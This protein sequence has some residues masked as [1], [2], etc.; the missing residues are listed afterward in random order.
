VYR[1]AATEAGRVL[2]SN[3]IVQSILVRRSV[4]AGEVDFGRS[5]IDLTIVLK[6]PSETAEEAEKLLAL[7]R[8]YRRLRWCVPALG[9][10][11]VLTPEEVL[12]SYGADPYRASLE[13]RCGLV[14]QGPEVDIPE[15]PI[16]QSGVAY[17]TIDWFRGY[18]PIAVKTGNR[19][20]L[21]KFAI[22]IWNA[23]ATA[24]GLIEQPYITRGEAERAWQR[25]EPGLN[26]ARMSR[27]ELFRQC[28]RL[29]AR[30]HA[31]FRPPLPVLDRPLRLR[32][33]PT[34]YIVIPSPEYPLA[35]DELGWDAMVATP[36][37]LD[38]YL[39]HVSALGY[40]RLG[41]EI[42]DLGIRPPVYEEYVDAL[43]RALDPFRL[44]TIGFLD[45]PALVKGAARALKRSELVLRYLERGESPPIEEIRAIPKSS[46]PL[47]MPSDSEYYREWYPSLHRD[48]RALW[49]RL[50]ALPR[51]A[52]P[53]ADGQ[54]ASPS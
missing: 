11:F 24:T 15:L 12:R 20:N 27:S 23:Y 53:A 50:D 52:T 49:E 47:R 8:C 30:V 34:R 51:A 48:Y 1:L 22:E 43:G 31:A 2:V 39:H 16:S 3:E 5:D 19:R 37:I 44:R 29:A 17:R 42:R 7:S 10:C 25:S 28:C 6:G 40:A 38:L 14:V 35:R 9:E 45:A 4:A 54:P 13:R 32:V 18:L 41:S 46:E 33:G 21:R 26:T 36:E